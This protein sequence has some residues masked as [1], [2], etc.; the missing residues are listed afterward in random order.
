MTDWY[1]RAVE[2]TKVGDY[3]RALPYA[4]RAVSAD[5]DRAR[6]WC[7]L[8]H[9]LEELA[10]PGEG[11]TAAERA[12][13]LD[14][15]SEWAH[16]LRSIALRN[17]GRRTEALEAAHESAKR[18]PDQFRVWINFAGTAKALGSLDDARRAAERAVQLAPDHPHSW[19]M[20][21]FVCVDEH[22]DE[23][24]DAATRALELAPDDS[25]ALNNL[26]WAWFK[27]G[28]FLEARELF[29]RGIA[30]APQKTRL[31]FNRAILTGYIDGL[32]AGSAEFARA[33]AHEL[34]L[35]ERRLSENLTNASAH[36]AHARLL[37][38]L[39]GQL[40]A[41]LESARHAVSLDPRSAAAWDE[42]SEVSASAGR[43]QLARYAS[44]RAVD[45]DASA[46][47]R[48]LMTGQIAQHSGHP[49]EAT[50]WARRVIS[51][52]PDSVWLLWARALLAFIEQDFETAR[53]RATA[54]LERTGERCCTRVFVA[55][56]CIARGDLAGAREEL[57]RS[58]LRT[59]SCNC[60]RRMHVEARLGNGA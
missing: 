20:L 28:R 5:P 14:P 11:L 16:R 27:Q 19:I 55:E 31:L 59:P 43:W 17:L 26:G 52:A 7:I 56:C 4:E 8:A 41:A 47:E 3:E 34:A 18:V 35:V 12:L 45:A 29:D 32:E 30:I 48:W 53:A 25:G 39:G 33:L 23:A 13:S 24:A 44:R 21:S 49:D 9:A 15:D 57:H 54:D 40:D 46:P 51:D 22:W 36:A 6:N 1:A 50:Q 10:R 42:L 2:L 58:R 60:Y 37:R 38:A